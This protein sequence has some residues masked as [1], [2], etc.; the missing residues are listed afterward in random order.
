MPDPS[1]AIF[2]V[3]LS[4]LSSKVKACLARSKPRRAADTAA[5]LFRRQGYARTGVNQILESAD[6]KAGRSIHHFPTAKQELARRVVDV[7]GGEIERRLRGFLD[8]DLPSPTSSTLDRLT[9]SPAGVRPARRAARSNRS[10]PSRSTPAPRARRIRPRLRR[11]ELPPSPSVF[12]PT[13]GRIPMPGRR[14]SRSSP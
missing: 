1:L 5:L 11:L 8:S 12:A 6:V 7:V 9:Q 10:P 14:R 13:A 4:D 2:Q 3:L